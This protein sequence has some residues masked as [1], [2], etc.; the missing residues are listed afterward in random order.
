VR[1]IVKRACF[2]VL[3]FVAVTDLWTVPR[4]CDRR[5]APRARSLTAP[6]AAQLTDMSEEWIALSHKKQRGSGKNAR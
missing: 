5:P 4:G 3:Q 2:Y 1:G 6:F